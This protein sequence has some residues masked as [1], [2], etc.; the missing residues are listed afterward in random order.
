MVTLKDG[1][2]LAAIS[3]GDVALLRLRD[4]CNVFLSEVK[5]LNCTEGAPHRLCSMGL[6]IPSARGFVIPSLARNLHL[7]CFPNSC[8]FAQIRG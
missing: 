8:L 1:E 2:R 6:E 7:I 5:S 4:V 3:P